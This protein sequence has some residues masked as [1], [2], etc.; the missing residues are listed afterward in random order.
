MKTIKSPAT[1]CI[2][3]LSVDPK[4]DAEQ[5]PNNVLKCDTDETKDICLEKGGT[6]TQFIFLIPI[7]ESPC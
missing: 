7:S 6:S 4:L 2:K 5:V 3:E 1:T